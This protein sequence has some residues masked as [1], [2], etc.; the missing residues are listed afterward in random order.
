LEPVVANYFMGRRNPADVIW[1]GSAAPCIVSDRFLCILQDHGF[2]GW[3]TYRVRVFGT[4]R[5]TIPG[6]H[7]FRVHGRCGP[8]DD[9]RSIPVPRRFPAG[10]STVWLGLYFDLDT[11]DGNDLFMP[12][13]RN[14][15]IFVFNDVKIAL[16]SA[17]VRNVR[18][19]PIE[20]VEQL[21]L[22]R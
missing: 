12:E 7:G 1:T 10:V 19:T 17:K 2:R 16:E 18:F 4:D 22:N 3:S 13:G 20:E 11:W 9:S 6:Y 15:R 21:F 5:E 14:S 8:I